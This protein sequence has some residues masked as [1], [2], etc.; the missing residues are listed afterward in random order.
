MAYRYDEYRALELD[1]KFKTGRL[2]LKELGDSMPTLLPLQT[3]PTIPEAFPNEL[4]TCGRICVD[5]S[6]KFVLCSNRGHDSIVVYRIALENVVPGT[7]KLAG[8]YHTAGH[9]PRHFR[10]STSGKWLFAANQDSDN[11]S[12]FAFDQET[13]ALTLKHRYPVSSPNFICNKVPFP[14]RRQEYLSVSR[15]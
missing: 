5:P 14:A 3:I 15:I 8:Y 4:N 12:V 9:T 1:E 11:L 2:D 13:G 10:F 6:G 7:L